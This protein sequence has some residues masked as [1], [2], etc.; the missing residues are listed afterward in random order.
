MHV[1]NA[2]WPR[3]PVLLLGDPVHVLPGHREY[4]YTDALHARE[5]LCEA[6]A[7]V[8]FVPYYAQQD[9][10][11][12]VRDVVLRRNV[13]GG[14]RRLDDDEEMLWRDWLARIKPI[15]SQW[16][17]GRFVRGF[18]ARF[19]NDKALDRVRIAEVVGQHYV[20]PLIK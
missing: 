13:K 8:V 17:D 10:E 9:I 4:Y 6:A 11:E 18:W 5:Q 20:E 12:D 1:A 19:S 14:V 3:T 7:H 15:Q 16:G 2:A